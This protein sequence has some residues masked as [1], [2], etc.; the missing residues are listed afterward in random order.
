[1]S[2]RYAFVLMTVLT[3]P[4]FGQSEPLPPADSISLERLPA[5]QP[6][7]ADVPVFVEDRSVRAGGDRQLKVISQ[8][9]AGFLPKY[10]DGNGNL[11]ESVVSESNGMIG[12]GPPIPSH[13]L[14]VFG[15]GDGTVDI[16][17]G[18]DNQVGASAAALFRTRSSNAATSYVSHGPLNNPAVPRWGLNLGGWN[19]ILAFDGNGLVIGTNLSKPLLL[20]TAS[21][22][23]MRINEFGNIAVGELAGIS[24]YI[25]NA[26]ASYT[27]RP[28]GRALYGKTLVSGIGSSYGAV[29]ESYATPSG[30]NN[31]GAVIGV[32]TYANNIGAGTLYATV[33]GDFRSG[34]YYNAPAPNN[35]TGT[36]S[37]ATGVQAIVQAGGGTV[38]N[39]YAVQASFNAGTGT[40]TNGYGVYI[41][42]VPAANDYGIYQSGAN[43]D[44]YFNGRIGIGTSTPADMLHLSAGANTGIQMTHTDP[45][46]G[47]NSIFF[48][49]GSTLLGFINQRG[50]A[51]TGFP[52]EQRRFNI[53]N[54]DASGSTALYAGG[55][56][57]MFLSSAGGIGVG[58]LTPAAALHVVGNVRVD[59]TI[60]GATVIGAVY[61][62]VAEWVPATTK[63]TPGTVVVMNP[64][65]SNEV[66][67]SGHAYDTMVAGVV[68][69]QPG[70]LLGVA[71][72]AKEQVATTGRVR[73]R[74]DARQSPVRIGD[75]LVT[76]DEP[77]TAMK[78]IPVELSG[79]AM[80]RPGTIIGKALEPLADGVGEIL[81]LLSLQ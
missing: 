34:V 47:K 40:I 80:H 54:A 46:S 4:L 55:V 16:E 17:V 45:T 52:G 37:N 7:P 72:E 26:F 73:V 59:G 18:N 43:D 68:S 39:G 15:N 65:K 57:R 31:I 66:M 74:V 49:E 27:K 67:A 51:F 23:R 75:L 24:P 6:P 12:I 30:A 53:G 21:V 50:T 22:E 9:V 25:E 58:T 79:I 10:V 61:Q 76:S 11:T 33:G 14:H 13:T 2:V 41:P 19:E 60:T 42:D 20:G 38:V 62:D 1:M 81:V 63:M 36:V 8:S 71:G 48:Y 29:L 78:S 70:I 77:G 32:A 56:T 3:V 69:A 44:N 35:Y 64:D 5:A 28:N